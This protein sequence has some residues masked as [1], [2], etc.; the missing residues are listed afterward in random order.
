MKA[1][2]IIGKNSF[3]GKSLSQT[4][5]GTYVSYK[6]INDLN[7]QKY[8]NIFLLSSPNFYKKKKII[9]FSFEKKILTKLSNQKLIF[10]STSKIYPNK[11]NCTE[12]TAPNPQ[13]FY[14]ENKLKLENVFNKEYQKLLIFRISNIFDVSNFNKNTFLG[15]MYENFFKR[16][17]IIFD[18]SLNSI[19]DLISMKSINKVINKIEKHS[20]IGTFNLGSQVGYKIKDIVNFYFG[21]KLISLTKITDKNKIKSQTLSIKKIEKLIDIS[22]Y[23]FHNNTKIE[24]KKC[25]K[26][27]F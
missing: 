2:L 15:M 4:L 16:E 10:F 1:N 13:N 14:A 20:L 6:D 24:L 9:N 7:F 19:R 17:K 5:K 21:K 8:K 22:K 3:V 12:E 11:L 26:F 23:D 25:K 27:F 18:I